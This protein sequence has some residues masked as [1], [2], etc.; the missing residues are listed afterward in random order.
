M[1]RD[2]DVFVLSR[3]TAASEGGAIRRPTLGKPALVTP[4]GLLARHVV[5]KNGDIVEAAIAGDVTHLAPMQVFSDSVAPAWPFEHEIADSARALNRVK[6][7]KLP[8]EVTIGVGPLKSDVP[9]RVLC[10]ARIAADTLQRDV[11]PLIE[12]AIPR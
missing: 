7:G 9:L 3:V 1:E 11:R 10:F 4:Y 2:D 12:P 8:V 6:K 5:A